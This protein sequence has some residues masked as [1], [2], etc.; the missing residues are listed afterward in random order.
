MA[1]KQIPVYLF[2]GFLDAGK[3]TFVQ[4][5]LEDKRFNSGEKTLLIRCEEGEVEYDFTS[6]SS[7]NV[8]LRSYEDEEDF[9]EESLAA[10][11]KETG[12]S[13]VI[14]EYNGM[15]QMQTLYDMI[16]DSWVV[17]Q[18]ICFAE[19]S[20][21]SVYNA[22]MRNL[23]FDKLQTCDVIVFNRCSDTETNTDDLHR[24]V[25]QVN[26]RCNIF[27]EYPDGRSIMD[28]KV[29]PLPFDVNAPVVKIE[30]RDYAY[31]FSDLME[32][33]GNY[34]GKTVSFK[35]TFPAT[36]KP[37]PA[38]V[39]VAGRMLMNCCAADTQFAGMACRCKADQMP[40]KGA[41]FILTGKIRLQRNRLFQGKVPMVDVMSVERAIQPEDPV[42]TFY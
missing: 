6:F 37:L 39:F 8:F 15:W 18:E 14:V 25:R 2:T 10:A 41:W 31:F 12:A 36:S 11:L 20:T 38:G 24:I 42:A 19:S 13:R 27:Y 22:N 28:E 32:N 34:E 33:M 5:T 3:S 29:D 35:A 17:A 40:A 23:V 1:D 9:T 26:R 30:D 16:P 21:F 7:P 4:S